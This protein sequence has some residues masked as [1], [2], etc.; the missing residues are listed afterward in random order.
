[1]TIGTYHCL[2]STHCGCSYHT[3]FSAFIFCLIGIVAKLLCNVYLLRVYFV[4]CQVFHINISVSSQTIV[5]SK[6]IIIYTFYLHSLH[7]LSTKVQTGSR[8]HNSALIFSKYV[9]ISLQIFWFGHSIH[10]VWYGCLTYHM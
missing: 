10:I 7:Q 5:N 4:L 6:E 3:N 1:M 2:Y 9:L 8:S